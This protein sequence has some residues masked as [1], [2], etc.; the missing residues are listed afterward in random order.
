M[1]VRAKVVCLEG[2]EISIREVESETLNK[3]CVIGLINTVV[4]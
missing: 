2:H 3:G 1:K 4:N